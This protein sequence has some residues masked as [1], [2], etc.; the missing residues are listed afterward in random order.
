MFRDALR[1]DLRAAVARAQQDNTIPAGETPALD[2]EVPRDRRHG[3]YATNAALLLAKQVGGNPREIA[4][5]LIEAFPPEPDRIARL[6]VAGP[7]FINITLAWPWKRALVSTITDWGHH[8]QQ[9]LGAGKRINV[10][11]VS[12]NPTG[13]L[14][15]GTGPATAVIG[16]VV[17]NLLVALG[18]RCRA[19]S[20]STMPGSKSQ[21]CALVR[22]PLPDRARRPTPVPDDGY[23]ATTVFRLGEARSP[24]PTATAGC[25]RPR[26]N[27]RALSGDQRSAGSTR[28]DDDWSGSVCASTL[29]SERAIGAGVAVDRALAALRATVRCT[30]M[31]REYLFPCER[32]SVIP[33]PRHL[34]TRRRLTYFA[35][36][37]RITPTS[38]AA[39][40]PSH[41]HWAIDH[42]GAV[43]RLKG[44]LQALGVGDPL[45]RS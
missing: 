14:H 42:I 29:F 41:Q 13:P 30:T 39:L 31:P 17:A 24:M 6:D 35:A 32:V 25:T 19:S 3:D 26:L 1:A 20:T 43:P 5:R 8:G 22:G 11:F 40:R 12:A 7:G 38:S 10:E 45:Q 9:T 21:S 27:A 28:S 4:Q 37:S 36:T 18:T 44:G 15:V 2:I 23:H 34:S 33:K 16:D